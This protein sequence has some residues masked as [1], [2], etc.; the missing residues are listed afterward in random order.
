[1]KPLLPILTS[2]LLLTTLATCTNSD[3]AHPAVPLS[4]IVN[5]KGQYI[6]R[7]LDDALSEVDRIMGDKG[8]A[9]ILQATEDDM[10]WY[11]MGLG[12]WIRNN[13]G[14]WGGLRLAKYFNQLGIY[15]P[16]DMSGIILDSYWRKLHNKPIDL[17][18]QI[19]KYQEFWK[20]PDKFLKA[21]YPDPAPVQATPWPIDVP[22]PLNQPAPLESSRP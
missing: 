7:D 16:D 21:A 19:R 4:D 18:G 3:N 5:S 11:H 6:P 8:R 10:I 20:D 17:E 13:W 2:A 12:M 1:M 15:H 14:L 9:Q 22:T